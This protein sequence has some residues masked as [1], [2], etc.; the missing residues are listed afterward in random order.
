MVERD[1]KLTYD[2]KNVALKDILGFVF[3]SAGAQKTEMVK[4]AE[5]V[6]SEMINNK[7]RLSIQDFASKA[8]Y[9]YSNSQQKFWFKNNFFTP[10]FN[11]GLIIDEYNLES[12]EVTDISLDNQFEKLMDNFKEKWNDL[13]YKYVKKNKGDK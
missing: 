11:A 1:R 7:G 3:R 13:A 12:G 5:K 9:D 2:F 10:L 8:G 4:K 6:I